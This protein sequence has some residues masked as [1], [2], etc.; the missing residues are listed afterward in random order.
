MERRTY[1]RLY[2]FDAK[3]SPQPL[4]NLYNHQINTT[5]CRRQFLV[6]G[7]DKSIRKITQRISPLSRMTT[8]QSSNA[9]FFSVSTLNRD[10]PHSRS[11][12]RQ[13]LKSPRQTSPTPPKKQRS[14]TGR[15]FRMRMIKRIYK[16]SSTA[17]PRR[18][19][20]YPRQS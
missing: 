15:V 2:F 7:N 9:I 20:K 12:L 14:L 17:V 3:A 13:K 18:G 16:S 19:P 10:S 5:K 8:T 6:N 1:F 4:E 11:H